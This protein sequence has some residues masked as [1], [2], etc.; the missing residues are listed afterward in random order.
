MCSSASFALL[1]RLSEE[2]AAR[3]ISAARRELDIERWRLRPC[4]IRPPACRRQLR[5]L[6]PLVPADLPPLHFRLPQP[7]LQPSLSTSC[8]PPSTAASD[9]GKTRKFV[10]SPSQ[11]CVGT[12]ILSRYQLLCYRTCT[13][14][15]RACLPPA[16][17][18][19][20][21]QANILRAH[22][23]KITLMRPCCYNQ[24]PT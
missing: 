11:L 22:S 3:C 19:A 17:V 8:Y 20:A 23:S 16:A 24:A 2:T 12:L 13:A 14:H 18:P 15:S 6:P 4:C 21:R 5:L 9:I 7:S 10:E 1:S